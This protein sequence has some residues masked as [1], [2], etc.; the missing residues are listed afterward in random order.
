MNKIKNIFKIT[1]DTNVSDVMNNQKNNLIILLFVQKKCGLSQKIKSF[2]YEMSHLH[3]DIYFAVIDI[4]NYTIS[5][6]TNY[7]LNVISTPSFK[8][9]YKNKLLKTIIIEDGNN[10]DEII[11]S[12]LFINDQKDIIYNDL[13]PPLLNNIIEEEEEEEE[14]EEYTRSDKIKKIIDL[15][16]KL[17]KCDE[18][19]ISKLKWMK[20]IHKNLCTEEYSNR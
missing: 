7:L 20:Y 19:E 14:K 3:S 18:R 8:V 9:Y 11:N 1:S 5:E 16:D 15:N 2:I 17:C 12:I 6:N 13:N 4:N 10:K